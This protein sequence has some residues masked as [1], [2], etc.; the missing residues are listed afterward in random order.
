MSD[1]VWYTN[2]PY[3]VITTMAPS[4]HSYSCYGVKNKI[5]GVTEAYI[6]QLAYAKATADKYARELKEGVASE[7]ETAFK[8][9]AALKDA[10]GGTPGAPLN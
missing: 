2:H 4:A 5:T 7:E 8:L 9:L 6:G 1:N 3:E 10:G